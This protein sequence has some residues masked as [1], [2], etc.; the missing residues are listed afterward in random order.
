MKRPNC[1]AIADEL[2]I[3]VWTVYRV[4]N[5][6]AQVRPA[7]R[8]RVIDAL[9]RHGYF[10][11]KVAQPQKIVFN[12]DAHNF[13]REI[14][15]PLM[16]NLSN[17]AF[18]CILTDCVNNRRGFE[19]AVAEA[20]FVVWGTFPPAETLTWA[21]ALNPEATHINLA[22]GGGGDIAIDADNI[23]GG[24]MAAR[25]LHGYGHSTVLLAT[26]R[27]HVWRQNHIDRSDSF[28]AEMR[29]LN[30]ECDI[31][32]LYVTNFTEWP[33]EIGDFVRDGG[34]SGV[35][36][37]FSTFGKLPWYLCYSFERF[38]IRIPEDI[39]LLSFD[40]PSYED[41][42]RLLPPLDMIYVDLK[43]FIQYLE[44]YI[45]NRPLLKIPGAMHALL[46][47]RLE[48]NGSLRN[49]NTLT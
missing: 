36:A 40:H 49:L 9:N 33:R 2:E 30:P 6:T 48:I 11:R 27:T 22:G 34:H 4:L 7:M 23:L 42:M 15:L 29:R 24:R 38:G 8:D 37:I 31:R 28:C 10:T 21:K 18:N 5:N 35:T 41:Y 3:S 25:H 26:T 43:I 12:Q 14:I 47:P 20:A 44:Y 1:Q 32:F 16:H 17:H 46:E 39:G 45:L 13:T 19:D